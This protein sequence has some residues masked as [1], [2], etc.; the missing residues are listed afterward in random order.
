MVPGT[1]PIDALETA[2][3][4]VAVNPPA[5]LREQLAEPGG[6]LRA[7]RR[8]LPDD[9]TELLVVVDQFE[10][11]FTMAA[12]AEQ[13][14]FLTELA[15]AITAPGSPLRVV[16]TLRADHYDV[17]LRHPTFAELVTDGTVT[18]RP[19]TPGE[20]EQVVVRPAAGVG[21]EVEPALVAELVAG[22]TERPAALPLLQFSLTEVFERRISGVM[23]AS[24]HHELGGLTGAVRGASRPDRRRRRRGRR[25]RGPTDLRASGHAR[26]RVR[27]HPPAGVAQRVRRVRAD[28]L[29]AR[30]VRL[31]PPA[32]PR[33]R[34]REPSPTVEV[35]HE[36]LLRDWPRLRALARRRPRRPSNPACRRRRR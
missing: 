10:E 30:R 25:S 27:G 33:A 1:D 19:M 36:A 15:A 2:L 4:R 13:D 26:R 31:G 20:L 5:S 18:V 6:L 14:R 16:A 22:V 34:R 3:L 23:F 35:A 12:A 32:H 28:R 9:G 21:V 24:T 8:V 17:P 29:A 7:V 11:L